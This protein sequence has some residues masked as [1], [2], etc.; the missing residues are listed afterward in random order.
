MIPFLNVDGINSQCADEL[1]EASSRVLRSGHY[2]L[3]P[4]LESLEHELAASQGARHAIGVGNGLD[5]LTL[6]LMALGI[7]PGDEVIV[8]GHTFIATWLAVTRVG[9]TIVPVDVRSDTYNIDV[10]EVEAAVTSRTAAIVP[11]HLYGCPADM[12]EINQVARRHGLPIIADGAQSIGAEYLGT[13]V[14][15]HALATTLSFYPA[16]N[17]GAL[18]D[19][20]AVL[21]DDPSLAR[22][23]QNLR[24]YGSSTK[25]VHDE[26]GVNS[27]LDE[28]QAAFL[29]VKLPYLTG[30]NRRRGE[31]ADQML[32]CLAGSDLALPA[33]TPSASPVWHLFVVRTPSRSR[34][35]EALRA[36][37]IQTLIHYPK[38]PGKQ[39]AYADLGYP[40][41]PVTDG[42]CEEV[43]SLPMCPTLTDAQVGAVIDAVTECS[44]S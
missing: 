25:Y 10:R 36:L 18:G 30:W 39:G 21:T 28:L 6:T 41:L 7:G 14:A 40:P 11:V 15:Q 34:L 19:G 22:Q 3:G 2:V 43:L 23:I 9:A 5:A 29:R 1:R 17:L 32:Q 24:N 8:P 12:V 33:V 38:P 4:E 42:L 26:I 31:V 20:G 27:R 44:Q 13:P 35:Q 16:K 37:G